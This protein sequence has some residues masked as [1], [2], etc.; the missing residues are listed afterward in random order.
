MN[1][2]RSIVVLGAGTAGVQTANDLREGGYA[3]SL[4]I[5]GDECCAPYE[6]PPL[7]KSYLDG[8][9][10]FERIRLRAPQFYE[11]AGIRLLTGR[12]A[13]MI[14]RVRRQVVVDDGSVHDY[15]HLVIAAGGRSRQLTVRGSDLAGVYGLRTVEDADRLRLAVT[16]TRDVVIVGA[17][18]IG[19]EFATRCYQLGLRPV[20]IDIAER[21]MA[22]AVSGP[23]AEFLAAQHRTR[24]GSFIMGT[25]I[26]QIIGSEGRVCAV[27][28]VDGRTWPADVIVVG[29]GML[30]NDALARQASLPTANG[31][32]VDAR[33]LTTDDAISVVGD[34]ARFPDP[35]STVLHT[36]E[37]VQNAADQARYVASRLLGGVGEYRSVPWFW[38]DQIGRR[39]QLAGTTTQHDR[40][41]VKPGADSGTLL[42]YCFHAGEFVGLETVD[43]PAEHM[44]ARRMLADGTKVTPEDVE[45]DDFELPAFWR[46]RRTGHPSGS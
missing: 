16:N 6:R 21:P 24:G 22:R 18:F 14:D 13:V 11:R 17:G 15:D 12:R 36:C 1:G 7:S 39:L 41:V 30:A 44:T 40:L 32:I 33:L 29:I 8:S 20:I 2:L 9:Q 5:I 19:L 10:T 46:A 23:T 25:T 34:C 43:R 38:S 26:E 27:K 3:G 28:A 31:V 35:H 4:T 45:R 42:T 37:S